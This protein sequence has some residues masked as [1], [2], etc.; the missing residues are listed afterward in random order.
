MKI[1]GQLLF[2]LLITVSAC[3][4]TVEQ[5]FYYSDGSRITDSTDIKLVSQE[6]NTLLQNNKDQSLEIQSSL[7]PRSKF[8][9][10]I[11]LDSLRESM[12]DNLVERYPEYDD[13]INAINRDWILNTGIVILEKKSGRIITYTNIGTSV[14]II[15][16]LPV[17]GTSNKLYGFILAMDK[18]FQPNDDYV[19]WQESNSVNQDGQ[20]DTTK[21]EIRNS[22]KRLFCTSSYG[23]IRRYPYQDYSIE[24]WKKINEE[25]KFNL[26]FGQANPNYA[27]MFE[28]NLLDLT[29]VFAMLNNDGKYSSSFLVD[30]VRNEDHKVIYK[31]KIRSEQLISSQTQS[32]MEEFL[33]HNMIYGHG[34]GGF[35]KKKLSLNDDHNVFFGESRGNVEWILCSDQ[36]YTIGIITSNRL[37]IGTGGTRRLYLSGWHSPRKC[38]PLLKLVLE[39]LND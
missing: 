12:I 13:Q 10:T 32:K 38:V 9:C 18:E 21:Y 37:T 7:L 28:S 30:S 36:T 24:E 29:K 14:D 22:I 20:K 11:L 16:N 17:V 26:N 33:N 19:Y 25:M 35:V 5:N 27:V 39:Q 31:P 4:E 6:I 34:Q 1:R 8:N 23:P 15:S 3:T 2:L